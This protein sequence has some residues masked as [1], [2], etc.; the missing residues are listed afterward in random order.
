MA[1]SKDVDRLFMV[2]E[3]EFMDRY[4]KI[5]KW[6]SRLLKVRLAHLVL[7]LHCCV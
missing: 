5:T 3:S 4:K 7:L 6:K 2:Q 1:G